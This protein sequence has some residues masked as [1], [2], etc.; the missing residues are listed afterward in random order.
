MRAR[1][2]W[3][4][5]VGGVVAVVLYG[6][7]GWALAELSESLG[8]YHRP[9]W[10]AFLFKAVL[11]SIFAVL[12]YVFVILPIK[13]AERRFPEGRLKRLL[14]TDHILFSGRRSDG[15]EGPGPR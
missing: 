14:F 10:W 6:A 7:A 5:V 3:A 2:V 11:V 4:Y 15:G 1:T 13:W 8:T 9:Q 12:A